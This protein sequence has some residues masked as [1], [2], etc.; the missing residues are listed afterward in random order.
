MVIM[1]ILEL[2]SPPP[3]GYRVGWEAAFNNGMWWD[4]PVELANLIEAQYMSGVPMCS[5]VWDWGSSRPGSYAPEGVQTSINRYT[6]N[7]LMMQQT[8][9]DNGR[10]RNVRRIFVEG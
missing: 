6:I 7:F 10:Q 3:A 9:S 4:M 5:Y 8:N 1:T 2:G